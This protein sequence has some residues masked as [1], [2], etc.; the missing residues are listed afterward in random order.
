MIARRKDNAIN[1]TPFSDL[2]LSVA[3]LIYGVAF[4][5]A[6]HSRSTVQPGI[7]TQMDIPFVYA[8][9]VYWKKGDYQNVTQGWLIF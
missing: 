1:S 6:Q 5:L 4:W 2:F 9:Y 8:P 3:C 7:H